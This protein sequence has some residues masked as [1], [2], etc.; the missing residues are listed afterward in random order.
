MLVVQ[1]VVVQPLKYLY[2][3]HV[4]LRYS[5]SSKDGCR[6]RGKMSAHT[7]NKREIF[8]GTEEKERQYFASIITP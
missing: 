3:G 2:I 4:A 7:F 1:V 5:A 8:T 6:H